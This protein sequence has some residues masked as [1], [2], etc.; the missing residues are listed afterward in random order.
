MLP[1]AAHHHFQLV[2]EWLVE[3]CRTRAVDMRNQSINS[4]VGDIR[5]ICDFENLKA[6]GGER[7]GGREHRILEGMTSRH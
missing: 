7:V 5:F 6:N 4:V 2:H 1:V 3:P